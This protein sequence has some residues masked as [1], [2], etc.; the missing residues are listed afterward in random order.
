MSFT[1]N[2]SPLIYP[3]GDH[4]LVL[5]GLEDCLI[6]AE[7]LL[8]K[9]IP[10]ILTGQLNVLRELFSHFLEIISQVDNYKDIVFFKIFLRTW[11]L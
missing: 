10:F 7:N 3:T 11:H 5:V 1:G 4:L 6:E 2:F 9:L 8:V